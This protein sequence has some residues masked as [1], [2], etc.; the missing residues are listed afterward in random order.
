MGM[1]R[2]NMKKYKS[3]EINAQ[4]DK[5]EASLNVIVKKFQ[6]RQPRNVLQGMEPWNILD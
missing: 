3:A 5:I 1:V 6:E 4:L 2:H